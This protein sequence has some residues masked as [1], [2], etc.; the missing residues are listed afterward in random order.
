MIMLTQ[1]IDWRLFK[2]EYY[3]QTCHVSVDSR[4][5]ERIM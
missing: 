2:V 5:I 1:V 3:R 4:A